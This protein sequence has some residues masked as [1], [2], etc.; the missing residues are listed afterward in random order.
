MVNV[1]IAFFWLRV[2]LVWMIGAN[3]VEVTATCIVTSEM[4]EL[5]ELE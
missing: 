1:K 3:V 5:H 4:D 2:R